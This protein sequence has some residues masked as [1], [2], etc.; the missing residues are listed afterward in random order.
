MTHTIF[1][2]DPTSA[3]PY[4]LVIDGQIQEFATESQ[5]LAYWRWW[6]GLGNR[7]DAA[8]IIGEQ[9]TADL[10]LAALNMAITQRRPQAVIHHSDQG[11]QYTSIAF[12][13]R[14]TKLGVRPSMGRSRGNLFSSAR[15][16]RN[17]SGLLFAR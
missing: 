9:M 14:C 6:N 5:R 16:C 11:A 17:R 15:Y 8:R 7:N 12:G 2:D 3:K 10:V 13:E 1:I 4:K